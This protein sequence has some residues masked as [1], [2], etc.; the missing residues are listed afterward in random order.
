[1]EEAL[2]AGVEIA[3]VAVSPRAG[4]DARG[5]ELLAA[6]AERGVPVR[7]MDDVA[8]WPPSPRRRRARAWWPWPAARRSTRRRC[9]G[10]RP[11]SLVAVG[12]QNPGNVGAL[13]RTAEAAGATGAYL[14]EGC[15]DPFSWKALR[16]SMGSAFRLPHL[17]GRRASRTWSRA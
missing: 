8:R 15:A 9:S 14:A 16:G 3:E 17:R 5:R 1:M 13:L 6:L 11:C 12:I 10:A 7:R 2:A 4:P